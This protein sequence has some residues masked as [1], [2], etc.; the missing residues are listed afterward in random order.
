MWS[1]AGISTPLSSGET[2]PRPSHDGT[3]SK[4]GLETSG[5]ECFYF[6]KLCPTL[7]EHRVVESDD[8]TH[9]QKE[10]HWIHFSPQILLDHQR[11][12]HDALASFRHRSL[13]TSKKAKY[14]NL[15][16]ESRLPLSVTDHSLPQKRLNISTSRLSHDFLFPYH[17]VMS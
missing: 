3:T 8:W 17:I 9:L 11:C 10:G 6:Y 1:K 15:K 4:R 7:C 5:L 12:M 16:I 2:T 14:L 13:L